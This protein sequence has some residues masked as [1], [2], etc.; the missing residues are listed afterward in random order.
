MLKKILLT[1]LVALFPLLATAQLKVGIMN[2][3]Q[4]M[5]ALPETA[6][7]QRDLEQFVQEKQQEF[8]EEYSAWMEAVSNFEARVEEG[9]LSGQQRQQEEQEL[10]DREEELGN[11]ETR[12]QGQIQDRQNE[13]IG[14]IMQQVENAM[15]VIA[16]EL[17]LDYV[18]NK[19]TSQGDPVVYYA[20][21]RG[22][23]I[24]DLI[25]ERITSN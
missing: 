17:D 2:P 16:S 12:I 13:L 11:L 10:M 3:E 18:L 8:S 15:G 21:D 19:Q 14:P 1:L 4:V 24:T 6:E 22:T 20:S 25:I 23:D 7:I 9:S 5:D